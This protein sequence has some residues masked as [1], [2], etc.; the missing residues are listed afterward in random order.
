MQCSV[1]ASRTCV[2]GSGER[3]S[4]CPEI[5]KEGIINQANQFYEQ[6]P[7]LKK[8]VA[9]SREVA[10]QGQGLWSRVKETIEFAQSM[11][12]KKLGLACCIGLHDETREL[13]KIL[14][15]HDFEVASVMCKTG[16][17][18][19]SSLG[20]PRRY[21][22]V[23]KTGYSLGYVACNPV[24][25]ALLLNREKTD[26]NLIVGLCVGHDAIF[27]KFSEASVSTLIA[28]DRSSGHNPASILYTFY[29]DNFFERRPNPEGAFKANL[30]RVTL[31]DIY[32]LVRKKIKGH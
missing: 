2:T 7:E 5:L 22:I 10:Q 13:L 9:R 21:R 14:R 17:L 29:G 24:A 12:Y 16:S 19:K 30:K 25:Q 6:S 27:T 26:L 32:R 4:D 8:I 23:A 31:I 18:P 15:R 3:P 11:G 1:C 28:K 20:V